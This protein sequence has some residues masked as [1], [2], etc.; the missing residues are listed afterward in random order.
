MQIQRLGVLDVCRRVRMGRQRRCLWWRTSRLALSWRGWRSSAWTRPGGR[1]R[2]GRPARCAR[3]GSR[4]P[5]SSSTGP[6]AHLASSTSGYA[7]CH[8]FLFQG[9]FVFSV[10]GFFWVSYSHID[11]RRGEKSFS[12]PP[13]TPAYQAISCSPCIER[14]RRRTPLS[15]TALCYKRVP[16]HVCGGHCDWQIGDSRARP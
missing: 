4:A 5:R 1:C 14:A 16:V 15:G 7:S 6:T 11:H 13:S 9:H 10:L 8:V 12:T 2:R 3:P